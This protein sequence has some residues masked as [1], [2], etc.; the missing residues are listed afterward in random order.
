[1]QILCTQ[2]ETIGGSHR[3]DEYRDDHCEHGEGNIEPGHEPESPDL[4]QND[5]HQWQKNAGRV[6][7]QKDEDDHNDGQ[8]TGGKPFQ[9]QRRIFGDG[10]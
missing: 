10:L 3:D 4:R 2:V 5:G 7:E 1:M 9:I 6:A 8:G